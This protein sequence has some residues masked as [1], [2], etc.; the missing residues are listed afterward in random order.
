MSDGRKKIKLFQEHFANVEADFL[1][2][3]EY[4]TGIINII[5]FIKES[6]YEDFGIY[7]NSKEDLKEFETMLNKY[8][9]KD[10]SEWM[11]EKMRDE[12]KKYIN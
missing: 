7:L 9:Y 10:K 11:R 8:Y 2:D 6:C 1:H 4:I 12:I 3:F 5:S